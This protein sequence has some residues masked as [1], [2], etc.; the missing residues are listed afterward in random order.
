MLPA[1]AAPY[2]HVFALDPP[3]AG[4][5]V[6]FAG[7]L[8]G[9]GFAHCGW[10]PGEEAV[11]RASVDSRRDLRGTVAAVYRAVREAAPAPVEELEPVLDAVAPRA[12]AALALR[13]LLE[14]SLAHIEQGT[15]RLADAR[16]TQLEQSAAYR[17]HLASPVAVAA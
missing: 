8:P 17:A 14:L 3:P 5:G 7:G 11:A 12:Q 6:A 2:T 9:A 10:G 4:D 1:V 13:V 15:L 16:P